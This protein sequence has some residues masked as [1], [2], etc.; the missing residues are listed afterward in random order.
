MGLLVT[1]FA[2]AVFFLPVC[3]HVCFC[4]SFFIIH[5]GFSLKYSTNMMFIISK[6]NSYLLTAS[7]HII[8]K[9]NR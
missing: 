4:I 7:T 9:R 1:A 6:E 8:T 2:H 3:E 5:L